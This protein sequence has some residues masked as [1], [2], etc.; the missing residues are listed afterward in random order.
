MPATDQTTEFDPLAKPE[1]AGLGDVPK[2]TEALTRGRPS[3]DGL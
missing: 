3:D 1:K 2:G